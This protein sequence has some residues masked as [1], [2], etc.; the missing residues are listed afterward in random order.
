MLDVAEPS[1]ELLL[2]LFGAT[3]FSVI[4]VLD[5]PAS[6]G[7]YLLRWARGAP[8]EPFVVHDWARRLIR[9]LS[10]YSSRIRGRKN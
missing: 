8:E 7:R 6:F 4:Y 2:R 1:L 10:F 5:P 9:P 3:A